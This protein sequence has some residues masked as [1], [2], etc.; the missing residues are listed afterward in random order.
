MTPAAAAKQRWE[1]IQRFANTTI[2]MGSLANRQATRIATRT[3]VVDETIEAT[4]TR[5]GNH[6]GQHLDIPV[7]AHIAHHCRLPNKAKGRGG[8][9]GKGA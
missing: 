2:N 7:A 6:G 8:G 5:F 9:K 1:S 4:R 3:G